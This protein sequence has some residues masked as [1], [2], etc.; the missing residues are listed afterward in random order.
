MINPAENNQFR[1]LMLDLANAFFWKHHYILVLISW[2]IAGINWPINMSYSLVLRLVLLDFLAY[3]E[4]SGWDRNCLLF[5]FWYFLVVKTRKHA[6]SSTWVVWKTLRGRNWFLHHF[7]EK[8]RPNYELPHL[9]LLV[10]TYHLDFER[11]LIVWLCFLSCKIKL[12]TLAKLPY[13]LLFRYTPV[14]VAFLC[15]DA[16]IAFIWGEMHLRIRVHSTE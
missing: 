10:F 8:V 7:R 5:A 1:L 12:C 14:S 2:L 16:E 9:F 13:S 15:F 3:L 4:T 11:M 6:F